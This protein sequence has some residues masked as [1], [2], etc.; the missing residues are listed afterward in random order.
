MLTGPVKDRPQS[1]F[2]RL[3][4]VRDALRGKA[5]ELVASYLRNVELAEQAGN[6]EVALKS[7][8]WLILHLPKDAD[9]AGLLD[10]SID[11]Q[12][13]E[14]GQIDKTPRI[15]IGIALGGVQKPKPALVAKSEVIDADE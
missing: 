12:Q 10:R 3:K 11:T 5:E 14:Q 6:H 7:L 15:S 13:Q 1:P 9:G 2:S 8:Q 4:E